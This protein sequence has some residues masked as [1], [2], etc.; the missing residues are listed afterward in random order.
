[1]QN[2]QKIISSGKPVS[3]EESGILADGKFHVYLSEKVP[4]FDG[5][6]NVCGLCGVGTEITHQKNI[7]EEL[8]RAKDAAEAA[9]RAK[10]AFLANMSHEFRTPLNAIL[11]FS[12]LLGHSTNLNAEERGDLAAIRRGGE[13]L[14]NLV[15][16]VLDM[17]KIE[18]GRAVLSEKDLEMPRL[19]ADVGE[20]VSLRAGVQGPRLVFE[21]DAAPRYIRADEGK[22]RQVLVNLLGNAIKFTK[23]GVIT[24][25]VRKTHGDLDPPGGSRETAGTRALAFEVEDT[26]PGVAPDELD[27]LFDAFVQAETGREHREGTGLGLPISREFVRMMGGDI[28]V[29][30]EVGKGSIFRFRIQ[31]VAVD[32]AKLEPARPERRVVALAPGQPRYRILIV[33]D[34]ESNRSLLLELL[35]LPGFELRGAENGKEAVD[36]QREWEPHL[37]FMD[38]RMPVM[39]GREA[40][41]IIRNAEVEKLKPGGGDPGKSHIENQKPKIKIIAVTANAFEED[42]ADARSAGCDDFVRKPF[43][44]SRIFDV[45]HRCLGARFVHETP[46]PAEPPETPDPGREDRFVASL[47]ALPAD[48]AADLEQALLNIE[49]DRAADLIERIRARDALLADTLRRGFD[50]FEY[51][52]MLT[53]LHKATSRRQGRRDE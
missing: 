11:G 16:D 43:T 4:L 24:V 52:R 47:A 40:T 14:L 13:H 7:E 8:R 46:S 33:D 20:I 23:K 17:S 49:L 35:A 53:L 36:I 44:E 5:D 19:L 37:I 3:I 26:G 27:S 50:D 41:K 10:S 1:M 18:A 6:G 9:N 21:I 15:N 30:S 48:V 45:I 29:E 34:R 28:T 51:E 22:L 32:G 2:D 31:V 39:D 25:R 12:Q 42:R 38:M